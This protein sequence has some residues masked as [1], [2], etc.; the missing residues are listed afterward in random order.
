MILNVDFAQKLI[1][2]YYNT[3][4]TQIIHHTLPVTPFN[5]IEK[6]ET[7]HPLNRNILDKA[8]ASGNSVILPQILNELRFFSLS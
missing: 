1:K 6:S 8:N 2:L 7:I 5:N 3:A 4:Y